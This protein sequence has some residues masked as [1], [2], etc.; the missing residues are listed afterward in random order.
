[1]TGFPLTMSGWDRTYQPPRPLRGS[2][3]MNT[4]AWDLLRYR[5]ED[6]ARQW[7]TTTLDSLVA[8]VDA[9]SAEALGCT[10]CQDTGF[11]GVAE[12]GD[13][14]MLTGLI[15]R[16]GNGTYQ[17]LQSCGTWQDWDPLTASLEILTLDLAGDLAAAIT[18]GACGLVRRYLMPRAFLPPAPVVSAAPLSDALMSLVSPEPPGDTESSDNDWV[19]YAV[20]DELDPGAVLDLVRIRAAGTVVSLERYEDCSWTPDADLLAETGLPTVRLTSSQLADVQEQLNPSVIVADAPLTVSPNPKAEKLRRYWSTGRG[21]AKIRWNTPGDWVRCYRHLKKYMG[22]RAKGYCQNLHRRNDGVWTGD[23]RNPG[24][25]GHRGHGLLSSADVDTTTLVQIART[26]EPRP[27]GSVHHIFRVGNVVDFVTTEA[28]SGPSSPNILAMGYQF[29][30]SRIDV[31]PVVAESV[32]GTGGVQVVQDVIEFMR[33]GDRPYMDQPGS[34]VGQPISE[35]SGTVPVAI[36]VKAAG[37]PPSPVGQDVVVRLKVTHDKRRGAGSH[38][39]D[40]VESTHSTLQASGDALTVIDAT[41]HAF[42]CTHSTC[43]WRPLSPEES[44]L[45]SVR[46]GQWGRDKER[47]ISMPLEM[48]LLT[49]GIYYEGDDENAG[50]LRTLT[51]GGFP[52]APPDEWYADPKLPGPTPMVV[53]DDGRVFGHLATWDVTHIGMAGATHA[54]RSPSNYAYFLTGS[55]KTASG[56]SVNVGQLTLAGG[57]ADINGNAQAAVQHYD[58]TNSAVADVMVGED[59]YGI[60]AAGGM[61]PNVTPEQVRVFRA[62]PPSGDWR[63]INGHLEM[64]ACCS[65]NVPGFMNVRPTARVAGGA[66]LALVAAGTRELN[67]IRQAMLASPA[68]VARLETL[69]EKVQQLAV[70]PVEPVIVAEPVIAAPEP[71]TPAAEPVVDT[72]PAEPVAAEPPAPAEPDQPT[73]TPEEAARAEHIARVRDEIRQAK[74]EELRSRMQGTTAAGA[75]TIKGT[76]SFPISD[77]ASLK[78]AIQAFGRAGDKPA[79]KKHIIAMAYKL[80]RPDLIPSNWKSGK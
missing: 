31:S 53:E 9:E 6:V 68:V 76:D 48:E 45:A 65:V 22:L 62:S 51:A 49:D 59:Q 69:E 44:L 71:E 30:V 70:P 8:S 67:E 4:T 32:A 36:P 26:T 61:R 77:V 13:P 46:S 79:A 40:V 37:P 11:Y 17:A 38:E 41:S 19:T 43:G 56:K 50:I 20:V 33:F 42:Y 66:V 58:D 7:A 21:A 47:N 2:V 78:K 24:G 10:D 35:S 57:H 15:R 28:G 29:Q 72:T 52:V 5:Q 80:K 23:R 54:P 60:W 55:L 34:T 14:D 1:M 74:R 25:N 73:L 27:I 39:S 64:V 3:P 16:V 75:S 18:G 63:P 12:P